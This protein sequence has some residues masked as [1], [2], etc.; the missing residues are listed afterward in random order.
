MFLHNYVLSFT[1]VLLITV[2]FLMVLPESAVSGLGAGPGCCIGETGCVEFPT[3][4]EPQPIACLVNSV[5]PGGVCTELG[6]EGICVEAPRVIP[7]VSEL[8]LAAFAAILGSI[9]FIVLRRKR[10]SA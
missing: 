7:A 3:G 10:A 9:G 6:P 1:A 5:I 4:P 2:F 8:G